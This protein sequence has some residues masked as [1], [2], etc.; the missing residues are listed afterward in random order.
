MKIL[1]SAPTKIILIGEHFV[2]YGAPAI[3]IPVEKRNRVFLMSKK[4]KPKII[5]KSNLGKAYFFD[6]KFDG[7]KEFKIFLPVIKYVLKDKKIDERIEI[8]FL[9]ENIPKG[10]GSSSSLAIALGLALFTFLRKK[11]KKEDLFNCGQLADKIAHGGKPSGID[12]KTISEGKAQIF[13]KI[14]NPLKFNF[15]KID[16]KFP[17]KTSLI[18]VDTFKGKIAKTSRLIEKFAK[19]NK[20]SKKPEELTKKERE[21]LISKYRPIF[22]QFL[23]NCHR[24]GD[25]KKL[26]EVFNKNHQLLISVTTPEIERVRKIALKNGAFGAKITGAGG[27]GGA[28]LI[29]SPDNKKDDIIQHLKRENFFAF[30]I[31]VSREGPRIENYENCYC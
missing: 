2:V 21:Y 28:V 16:L 24:N 23:K 22:K 7:K 8:R 19:Y 4:G 14:F 27:K 31:Q 10:M 30:S 9:R 12:A 17:K 25:P 15:K 6:G 18:V 13:Q 1:T 26:G 3:S 5:L 29:L 11:P 20:V